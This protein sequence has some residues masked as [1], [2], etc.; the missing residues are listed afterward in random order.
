MTQSADHGML[1]D[2][3]KLCANTLM[4]KSAVHNVNVASQEALIAPFGAA[5]LGPRR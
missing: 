3:K 4:S 5:L 1:R 2:F